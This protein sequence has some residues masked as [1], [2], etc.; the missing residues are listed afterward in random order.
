MTKNIAR[1]ILHT[2]ILRKVVALSLVMVLLVMLAFPRPIRAQLFLVGLVNLLQ[3]VYDIIKNDLA[4]VLDE[5]TS[6]TRGFRDFYQVFLFPQKAIDAARAFVTWMSGYFNQLI[7]QVLKFPVMSSTLTVTQPLEALMRNGSLDFNQMSQHYHNVYGKVPE[8]TEASPLDRNLIDVDDAMALSS[9]KSLG[10]YE[11]TIHVSLGAASEI[12][13]R[14]KDPKSAPGA[15]PFMS[16]AGILASIQTQAMIQ[17]MIATQIR[18]EAAML[19]HRNALV[20]RDVILASEMRGH[21]SNF[22]KKK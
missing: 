3:T 9:V 22:L 15:A 12:E 13:D 5:I 11:A 7:N 14:I 2:L 6:L 16:A 19:A 10:V 18:Q 20:K 8:V 17:K 21:I 1:A 4:K